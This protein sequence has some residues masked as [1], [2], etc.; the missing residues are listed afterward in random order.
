MRTILLAG[1]A[2][3]V[4]ACANLAAGQPA[5]PPESAAPKAD[6]PEPAPPPTSRPSVEK[7]TA[8]ESK[9]RACRLEVRRQ[10]LRGRPAA[11]QVAICVA[12][13]RLECTKQ[14]A[15]QDVG[16][17]ELNALIRECMGERERG[18]R[19]DAR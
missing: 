15:A 19:K 7:S 9:R 13:A 18:S 8:T 12:E 11:K 10:G 14:A 16:N 1:C 5:P 2:A 17:R 4:M 3:A 6:T